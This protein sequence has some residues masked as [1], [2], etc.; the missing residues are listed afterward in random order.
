MF[1]SKVNHSDRQTGLKVDKSSIFSAYD[2]DFSSVL[3]TLVCLG[4]SVGSV[5]VT[6][7]SRGQT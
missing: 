2:Q 3:S 1:P 7:G 6:V 5:G 4:L